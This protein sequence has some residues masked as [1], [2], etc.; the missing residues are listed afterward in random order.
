MV[1]DLHL[2]RPLSKLHLTAPKRSAAALVTEPEAASVLATSIYFARQQWWRASAVVA[3]LEG[4]LSKLHLTAPKESAA[5]LVTE[6]EAASVLATSVLVQEVL[7]LVERPEG[8]SVLPWALSGGG[9]DG[10]EGR[11]GRDA[12]PPHPQERPLRF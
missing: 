7:T 12:P 2:D 6:P 11:C 4:P 3:Y 1:A 8:I 5:A 9:R 10:G